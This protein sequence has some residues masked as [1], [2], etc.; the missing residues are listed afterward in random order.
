MGR[1]FGR[2]AKSV[3]IVTHAQTG[4]AGKK[5]PKGLR[6]VRQ[7][8]RQKYLKRNDAQSELEESLGLKKDERNDK[9]APKNL[10]QEI[11][12]VQFAHVVNR[13]E[14]GFKH[15]RKQIIGAVKDVRRRYADKA[16][17]KHNK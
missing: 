13:R 2:G 14:K 17:K 9:H 11:A 5:T 6:G 16:H 12:A 10:A 8:K 15:L 1:G 4:K 3:A 7:K